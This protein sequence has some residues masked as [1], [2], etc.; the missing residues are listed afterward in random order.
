M[1]SGFVLRRITLPVERN[2]RVTRIFL[3]AAYVAREANGVV[4]C[5]SFVELELEEEPR[6]KSRREFMVG[7]SGGVAAAMFR[8]DA[9]ARAAAGKEAAKTPP[10][11]GAE[12]D[13]CRRSSGPSMST[14][15]G[16]IS[17]TA[18]SRPVR[19]MCWTR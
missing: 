19:V 14:A 5:E 15:P 11:A 9:I 12:E 3:I 7:L 1:I 13:Y 18:G 16:S 17:T 4:H 2:F 10:R 8:G 6:M